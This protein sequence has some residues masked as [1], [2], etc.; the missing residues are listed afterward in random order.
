MRKIRKTS[1]TRLAALLLALLLLTGCAGGAKNEVRPAD[2]PVDH[3]DVSPAEP[4]KEP[5]VPAGE[6]PA[7]EP[8]DPEVPDGSD[9]GVPAEE[10]PAGG[11]EPPK[12]GSSENIP[13]AVLDMVAGM[14]TEQ[15]AAQVLMPSIRFYGSEG[16]ARPV[17][18]LSEELV[19]EL[20]R[21]APGGILLFQ[22]NLSD[23]EQTAALTAALQ[24]ADRAGGAQTGLLL[25][26]DQEGGAVTRL[27]FGTQMP[28]NMALAATGNI[29]N[30]RLAGTV[31][32]EELA[33][34]G[35]NLDLAPD[36]DVNADPANP[37]IG[38]RSF[39]DDPA[40]VADMSAAFLSGLHGAGIM[41]A[42][43]HF[44][45]HG[46]TD[47][48]SHTG[49]PRIDKT[50]D[51]LL[52]CD[53]VP[54]QS[55]R[56][57][58]MIM[59]AHIQFPQVEP[60]TY[61]SKKTGE[62]IFLPATLSRTIITDVLRGELGYGGVVIS[63][64][65]GMDAIAA[66]FVTM[67]AARLCLNAGADMLLAPM[68]LADDK[69]I[70]E[71]RAYVSGI[72]AMA[73]DGTIPMER[74]DEAVARILALKMK[75][76]LMISGTAPVAA[77]DLSCVG[78][79]AH[80]AT[81]WELAEKAVTLLHNEDGVLPLTGSDSVVIVYPYATQTK[82][83][84]YAV[85]RL[86]REGIL[87]EDA[88]IETVCYES[89]SVRDAAQAARKGNVVVA[90]SALYKPAELDPLTSAGA[91]SAYLDALLAAAHE[92][93]GRFVLISAQ[94][95]YDTA[96]YPD[97]DAVL[98]CYNARGMTQTPPDDGTAW[99]QYGPNL[100]ACL[101][102][103]FGGCTPSGRLPVD[104]PELDETYGYGDTIRYPR[105]SGLTY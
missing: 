31:I 41:G 93:G 16:S 25:A 46:D 100:P 89:Q 14:T 52:A 99:G 68:N 53:L 55:A 70:E 20:K 64:A 18:E 22:E 62:E 27:T 104:V 69:G 66:H 28:G 11:Q 30:A 105:W 57:A 87:P 45:G 92:N 54:F 90:V 9:P 33:A 79:A 65:M 26:I 6:D 35:I 34:L 5:P 91:G 75:Y 38:V 61:V 82:S 84:A 85:D 74:L 98:A 1:L 39:S 102:A 101:Y 44:P 3:T 47:V 56:R 24:E 77:A 8:A 40:V 50:I 71:Y 49:L 13:D 2:E 48:D 81:E 4:E 7:E 72:A 73:E 43:K 19:S 59:T 78:S 97:A 51:E 42:L 80:H 88:K 96:R 95:P 37:I 10:E 76:G 36:A 23:A 83:V 63:D 60:E 17:T 29:E 58:D 94:L 15:K 103:A 32:G 12:E 67:D 86:K 21:L